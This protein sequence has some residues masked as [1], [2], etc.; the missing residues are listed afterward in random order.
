MKESVIY[1]LAHTPEAFSQPHPV[2]EIIMQSVMN[3]DERE[4]K[5]QYK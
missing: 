5:N 4:L 3:M 1:P 2:N